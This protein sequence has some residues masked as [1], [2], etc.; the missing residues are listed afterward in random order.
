VIE[1]LAVVDDGLGH[2]SHVVALGDG[3]AL[4]V[5]PA[6]FPHRQRKLAADRGWHIAWTADTHSHADYV[7]G[8]PEVAAEGATFLASAG[9]GLQLTHRPIAPGDTV[10]LADRI[11]LR[12]IATPGHTPDHL[13]YLLL[14]HGTPAALFSGG[15]LMVGALGRTDLLGDDRRD[16]LSRALFRSLRADILT[17]PDDLP[18][19]PTHGAG[20]FCSAP[21]GAARTTTIGQEKATNPLLAIDD[22]DHFVEVLRSG[23]GT[24]PTYFRELPERNRRGVPIHRAV[25]ELARLDLAQ[26]RRHLDDGAAL[27]D[28]RSIVDYAKAHPAGALSIQHRPVFGTWLGWLLDLDRPVVFLLDDSTDRH[29]LV[30]QCLTIGHDAILGELDGGFPAWVDGGLPVASIPLIDA[31]AIGGDVLDVR[32]DGEWTTGHIPGARHVEL[33][34]L[35]G[36]PIPQVPLTVMCGH[37]ERAMTA[38]SLLETAGHGDLTVLAGGPADWRDATGVDLATA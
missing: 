36:V 12:A 3:T 19:Y 26:V 32:Q 18:V 35:P 4:V 5:D 33:G 14:E 10:A 16:D 11:T 23:L 25:P 7:S 34:S 17:L 28:A 31:E 13:A 8:S 30:R 29:D 24:Y 6:R 20:S 38:A 37:G 21:A 1:V 9:A 27:V 2:S 22:E 15:S